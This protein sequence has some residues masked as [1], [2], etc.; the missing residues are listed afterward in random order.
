MESPSEE[1]EAHTFVQ[2][3][4]EKYD[5]ENYPFGQGIMVLSSPPESPIK[6]RLFMPNCII[7]DQCGITKA[8]NRSDIAAFCAH[9]VK[10]DLSYNQLNDWEE[11]CTIVSN[12]PHLVFLNLCT[13]PL[14]GVELEPSMAHAFSGVQKLVLSNT[15]VSWATVHTL[16]R[17]APGLEEL[18]LC[19]N[20]YDAVSEC[21]AACPSLR[22]LHIADNRLQKWA[23]VRKLGRMYPRLGKLVLSDNGVESVDDTREALQQLFP[24]LHTISLSNSGLSKWEDIERLNF[25][26]KLKEVR[27]MGI[28]LLQ[29]YSRHERR[30]LFIARLP[31]VAVLN[32]SVVE[33]RDREDSERLFIRY[34]QNLPEPEL[35]QR[36][37]ELVSK[38]G[39]L[40]PLAEVDLTPRSP[41]VN[42]RWDER[43]EAVSLHLELTVGDLKKKLKALLQLPTNGIRLFYIN[44]EM[45]S[46]LG[47]E[48]LRCGSRALHSYGIRDGDEIQVVPKVKRRCSSS[49][50]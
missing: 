16:T 45:C 37:H 17:H 29:P 20:G 44:R 28:P 5:S 49:N 26:P 39:H 13:N 40:E 43:L 22:L 32:G 2:A 19:L 33:D 34:Y 6:N 4:I 10:L 12:I 8:G 30:G 46:V 36:Y 38:Y 14:S 35:P 48:E 11:I 25:L 42:V 15:H 9:V 7:L 27:A 47:P 31:S 50:F 1:E 21:H 18:F 41:T 3:I 23:E 24:E